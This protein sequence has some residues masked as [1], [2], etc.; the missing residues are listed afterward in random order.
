MCLVT[1][2]SITS[3][4]RYEQ[5]W[6]KK[7]THFGQAPKSLMLTQWGGGATNTGR[8]GATP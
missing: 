3:G 6:W 7:I 8:T 2:G 4:T 1:S 5:P